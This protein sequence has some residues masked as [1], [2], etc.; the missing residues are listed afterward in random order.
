MRLW[1]TLLLAL[2]LTACRSSF[3]VTKGD[4]RSKEE[5]WPQAI[6]NYDAALNSGGEIDED[7][8]DEIAA[9][10]RH[11]AGK[12]TDL[13]IAQADVQVQA[14]AYDTAIS[15]LAS[16][17]AAGAF[18]VDAYKQRVRAALGEVLELRW[19][20]VEVDIEYRRY[21]SAVQSAEW[22][23]TMAPDDAA[24]KIKTARLR[25]DARAY[26][27]QLAAGAPPESRLFHL[28][29]VQRFGGTGYETEIAQLLISTSAVVRPEYSLVLGPG[30]DGEDC[31]PFLDSLK[32]ILTQSSGG[33]PVKVKISLEKCAHKEE[34]WK[35]AETFSYPNWRA[36]EENIEESYYAKEEEKCPEPKCVR[37]DPLGT[38]VERAEAP[39]CDEKAPV[40][41][42]RQIPVTRFQSVTSTLSAEVFHRRLA[43]GAKG[44]LRLEWS[45]LYREL[46]L[47]RIVALEEREVWTPAQS[48]RFTTTRLEDLDARVANETLTRLAQEANAFRPMLEA[49]HNDQADKLAA[50]GDTRRAEARYIAA[51]LA[52]GTGSNRAQG[53]FASQYGMSATQMY[54]LLQG[55]LA[56]QAAG[57][58]YFQPASPDYGDSR[59]IPVDSY[60]RRRGSVVA[61][62]G[63]VDIYASAES[64][65]LSTAKWFSSLGLRIRGDNIH[66]SFEG[67][68]AEL[69]GES[70]GFASSLRGVFGDN[71][72]YVLSGVA[73]E[74]ER[75]D[76][77]ERRYFL[78]FPVSFMFPLTRS[79]TIEA[80]IDLNALAL[81]TLF[82]DNP[83]DPA[84]YSPVSL[85]AELDLGGR[86]YVTGSMRHYL[87][88]G[89]EHPLDAGMELGLRL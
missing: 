76:S 87:G 75:A 83:E 33:V 73:W 61:E 62:G 89:K 35:E 2:A 69:A 85:R 11:A 66:L 53:Y 56:R 19:R 60:R 82:D 23:E 74:H 88:A 3:F 72:Y 17:L 71:G 54:M 28:R 48:Y 65:P 16:V 12:Y 29:A 10:R 46:L 43:S 30:T 55:Q 70:S 81:K 25:E 32:R 27:L 67:R 63:G 86:F 79:L 13:L 80:R 41:R 58:P 84:F 4:E 78:G 68:S 5:N 45:G 77:G 64:S 7:Y 1:A 51:S 22:L 50:I 59:Y 15:Q 52:L 38:C 24:L 14:G 40:L 49:E 8:R 37:F 21:L 9:K 57:I 31:R 20:Q 26:H 39:P 18:G 42:T 34:R 44:T 6:A 47:D 36:Q